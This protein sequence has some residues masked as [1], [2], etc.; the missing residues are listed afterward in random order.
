MDIT[1]D[2]VRDALKNVNHPSAG[3]DIVT[4][5]MVQNIAI[6][7]N[8]ITFTLIYNKPND[9]FSSSIKKA[10]IKVIGGIVGKQYEISVKDEYAAKKVSAEFTSLEKVKNIVAITSGKGGVGKSTI[11]VNLAIAVAHTGAKVALLDA[12]VYGPSIPIMF[13][14]EDFQPGLR[15]ENEKEWIVPLEKFGI[16]I[17]SVGFF[18]KPEEALIWRGPMA[19]NALKQII[20]QTDW[21]ELDY[22]FID[23][24]PGTGD[25]HLTMVQEMPVAGAIVVSTP[26]NLALADVIKAI[27]M[28]KS[29]KINVPVL[30]LVENMAWFTPM[31]LPDNKYFIF[32]KEGSKKLAEKLGIPLLAQIPIVQS[33]CEDSDIGKPT[34]INPFTL[35]G[36]AFAM[37]AENVIAEIEKR[38]ATLP[39]TKKV[40][41]AHQ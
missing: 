2:Q 34:A 15:K 13:G 10:C 26:Q 20:A 7:G 31:E 17:Q 19:T 41:I 6:E 21:G 11:A 27:N 38:N 29:E 36:K 30:G 12:D 37:L 33:I 22:L 25:I 18:F 5:N 3:T 8:K 14:A 35:E 23:S 32:G 4:L 39:P 1:I 16:K 28:F 24:P 40:E 9:P